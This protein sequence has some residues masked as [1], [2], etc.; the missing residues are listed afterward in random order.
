MEFAGGGDILKLI[1]KHKKPSKKL[2]SER[3]I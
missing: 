3:L 2:I 1:E